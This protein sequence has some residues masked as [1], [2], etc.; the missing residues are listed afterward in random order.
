[1]KL[2]KNWFRSDHPPILHITHPKAGSQWVYA[3][4]SQL[5]PRRTVRPEVGS[6]HVRGALQSGRIYPTVYLSRDSLSER[7]VGDAFQAFVVVRDL[8]D[9]LVSLYFSLRYSHG[10]ITD[11]HA[12]RRQK[13]QGLSDAEGLRYLFEGAI[14]RMAH[15]QA[16][17]A[18]GPHPIFRYEDLV[19]DPGHGFRSILRHCGV[20][21]HPTDLAQALARCSFEARSG[22]AMGEEDPSSHL[23][24]GLPGDH[25]NH[26]DASLMADFERSYGHLLRRF[27]Y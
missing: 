25:R 15:L 6:G 17:W 20:E 8:R 27:G 22:R 18:D 10:L 7:Q 5:Y 16:S 4:L 13:L 21:P 2:L 26:F 19:E 1:M 11:T 23:R 24:R 9:S 3:V 12:R 14:P